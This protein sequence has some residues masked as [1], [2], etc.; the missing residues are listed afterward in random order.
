MPTP[1]KSTSKRLESLRRRKGVYVDTVNPDVY[2]GHYLQRWDYFST[3]EKASAYIGCETDEVGEAMLE[4]EMLDRG[5]DFT[6]KGVRFMT[7]QSVNDLF[8][9]PLTNPRGSKRRG[10]PRHRRNGLNGFR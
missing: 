10:G 9:P 2:R 5:G 6:I 1:S 3:T 4:G 7:P 8:R